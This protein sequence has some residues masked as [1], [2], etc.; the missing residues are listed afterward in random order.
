MVLA[1][2]GCRTCR[3]Q[4]TLVSAPRAGGNSSN[5]LFT[6]APQ[7]CRTLSAPGTSGSGSRRPTGDVWAGRCQH[8]MCPSASARDH[9][10]SPL[11]RYDTGMPSTHGRAPDP[12]PARTRAAIF[13]AARDLSATDGEITVNALARRAGVSRAAFYSHFSGLDDLVAAMFGSMLELQ[14]TRAE[15]LIADGGDMHRIVQSAAATMV[16]YVDRHHAF[17]RGALEW[18]FSHSTYLILVKTLSDLHVIALERLG[19]EVPP[20][21]PIAEAARFY[22]GGTLDVLIQWLV[23]TGTMPAPAWSWTAHASPPLCFVCSPAGT[24]ACSRRTRSRPISSSGTCSRIPCTKTPEP[25][26]V[27]RPWAPDMNRRAL[28]SPGRGAAARVRRSAPRPRGPVRP[29]RGTAVRSPDPWAAGAG[30]SRTR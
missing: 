3:P 19:D 13:A 29:R 20:S 27:R 14:Y 7:R 2:A 15:Q 5:S 10:R 16:A 22:A 1:C 28:S 30:R 24:P 21:L 6:A 25:W 9:R 18:K 17:L 23:E 12:R 26:G 4:R 8:V 11:P